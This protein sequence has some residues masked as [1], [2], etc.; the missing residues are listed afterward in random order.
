M[1][2]HKT[3][4]VVSAIYSKKKHTFAHET[5]NIVLHANIMVYTTLQQRII[6]LIC[7]ISDILSQKTIVKLNLY[8][9]RANKSYHASE[10]LVYHFPHTR[11]QASF[12]C[13]RRSIQLGKQGVCDAHG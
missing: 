6:T 10:I 11:R 5:T 9:K 12:G 3:S 8:P 2:F 4:G 1:Q 13:L 7:D